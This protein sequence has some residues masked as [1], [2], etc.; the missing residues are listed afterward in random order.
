M[1]GTAKILKYEFHNI[2]RSKWM[3]GYAIFF[4]VITDGLF[5]FA[6]TDAKVI[7]SLMNIIL[8]VIPLASI[9][10]GAMYVYHSREFIEL[11]LSQPIDRKNIYWGIYCGLSFT[12]SAGF[13]FGTGLPF[14]LEGAV[15]ARYFSSLILLLITGVLLTW[16]F[17]AIAFWIAIRYED[18]VK[19]I[20]AAML[21]WMFFTVVYDGFILL[22]IYWFDDY[23]LE[24][25]MI[26]MSM[27]NPVDLARVMLLLKFNVSAMMGYTGAV[28]HHFF[29]AGTGLGISMTVLIL[30]IVTPFFLGLRYFRKKD[31]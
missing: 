18:K 8:A 31:F 14:L 5:R 29:S 23:P 1:D 16:I 25:V 3:A 26:G 9:I 24:T 19:G 30:W 10:F 27:A 7:V 13:V 4:L 15:D 12:L 11:L 6:G 21:I 17:T 2:L 20:G 22:I 28:F